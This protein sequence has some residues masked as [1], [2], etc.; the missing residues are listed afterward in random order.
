MGS[1]TAEKQELEATL[2]AKAHLVVADSRSQ[3]AS[4][5]DIYQAVNGAASRE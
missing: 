4:R 2:L 1:D 3:C 5:G